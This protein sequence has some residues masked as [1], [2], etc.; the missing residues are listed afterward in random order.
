MDS[1]VVVIT[2]VVAM[3]AGCAT[4]VVRVAELA[5]EPTPTPTHTHIHIG[6]VIT[7]THIIMKLTILTTA[8]IVTTADAKPIT[9]RSGNKNILVL[10]YNYERRT[11]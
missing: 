11:I 8:T 3:G 6:I 5:A 9:I 10:H 2:A 7:N 4:T 1:S